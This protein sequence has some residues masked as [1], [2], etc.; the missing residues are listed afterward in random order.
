MPSVMT[1]RLPPRGGTPHPSPTLWQCLSR[2]WNTVIVS[3]SDSHGDSPDA[4]SE[5]TLRDIG[6][7]R[8]ELGS[9]RAEVEGLVE[10][11]RTRALLQRVGGG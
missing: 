11:T 1:L 6:L 2:A 8:S 4:L 7:T 5:H 10:A 3:G 9:Y